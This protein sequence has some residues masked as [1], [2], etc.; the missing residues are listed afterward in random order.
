MTDTL[1][2]AYLPLLFW[3]GLG[4]L[5]ARFLPDAWPRLIGRGLYWVGI[6]L[7]V[8][9]LA[10][11]TDFS[12]SIGLV[13][14]ITVLTLVGSLGLAWITLSWITWRAEQEKRSPLP[15]PLPDPSPEPSQVAQASDATDNLSSLDPVESKPREPVLSPPPI[16][17]IDYWRDPAR[18][19][20][21]VLSSMIAN[22]GFVGL[23]IA[24]ILVSDSYLSWIVFYSVTQNV[25][26]TYGIGV[27]LASYFGR[28]AQPGLSWGQV[29]DVL[30]VPSLWAFIVGT[31]THSLAFAPLVDGALEVS[32]WV[33]IAV[34]LSLMGIRLSQLKGWS[35]L[36]WAIAP[37]LLK[38]L[39][40]PAL[41]GLITTLIGL[42]SEACLAVVLMAGMPSA[43][44]G[45]ILAE[46]YELDRELIASS[47]VLTS[48]LLLLT[49]PLW[50]LL[51]KV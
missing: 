46:E 27:F 4:V 14:L 22:T 39:V 19:G 20:S 29:R 48:G 51:F 50:L 49:I 24:P 47:I 38:V 12:D 28:S 8:F 9:A 2:H 25:V 21:F 11:S 45:L 17:P 23:A 15:D 13:P 1:L 30:T 33:V 6:P 42:P 3:P 16:P 26:G 32:V 44:A 37:T 36:K 18:R 7:E 31:A 35:S 40:I 34:A 5:L 41:V 43:F 10:H